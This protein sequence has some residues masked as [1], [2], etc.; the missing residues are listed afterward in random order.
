MAAL[1]VVELVAGP[2]RAVAARAAGL[3]HEVRNHAVK[4]KPV[5]ETGARK[6]GEVLDGLRHI[7][8][9]E[10]DLDGSFAGVKRG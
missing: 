5:V 10:L 6:L 2:A 4:D 1:L 9:E 8:G 3:D 7:A